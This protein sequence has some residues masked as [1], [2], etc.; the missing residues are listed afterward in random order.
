[1]AEMEMSSC[2]RRSS[3]PQIVASSF[4]DDGDKNMLIDPSDVNPNQVTEPVEPIYSRARLSMDG[5]SALVAKIPEEGF[6]NDLKPDGAFMNLRPKSPCY[7]PQYQRYD[8]EGNSVEQDSPSTPP[9]TSDSEIS[10][11]NPESS[12]PKSKSPKFKLVRSDSNSG[13]LIVKIPLDPKLKIIEEDVIFD[14]NSGGPTNTNELT[15]SYPVCMTSYKRGVSPSGQMNLVLPDQPTLSM[16]RARAKIH[17]SEDVHKA[18]DLIKSKVSDVYQQQTI[19]EVNSSSP[20][21]DLDLIHMM[22][23][24]GK[25]I[26]NTNEDEEDLEEVLGVTLAEMPTMKQEEFQNLDPSNIVDAYLTEDYII[27][28]T[29]S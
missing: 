16:L 25:I 13:R 18:I 9:E 6:K 20:K 1:M 10:K 11:D 8:S 21:E 27:L 4:D 19:V 22:D 17:F 14:R 5:G 15:P 24:N 3:V 26:W 12:A 2:R 7:I 29:S 23:E 28:E